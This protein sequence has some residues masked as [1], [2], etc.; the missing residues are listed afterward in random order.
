MARKIKVSHSFQN[1]KGELKTVK[2]TIDELLYK[3]ILKLPNEEKNYWLE[4]YYHEYC[5]EC[6][7]ERKAFRNREKFIMTDQCEVEDEDGMLSTNNKLSQIAD[8][9]SSEQVLINKLIVNEMLE[10]LD[11]I[12]RYVIVCVTMNGH[13]IISVANTLGIAESTVRKKI[14]IA[15]DKIKNNYPM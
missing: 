10:L 13:S 4:Y 2:F 5:K 6:N 14:K 15:L 7:Y 1:K 8:E 11:D 3:D 9:S 12:E